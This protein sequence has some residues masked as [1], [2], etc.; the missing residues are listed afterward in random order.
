MVSQFGVG[1]RVSAA[2][3]LAMPCFR[4]RWSGGPAEPAVPC[5]CGVAEPCAFA[6]YWLFSLRRALWATS[7]KILSLGSPAWDVVVSPFTDVFA[8]FRLRVLAVGAGELGFLDW[9]V[10]ALAFLRGLRAITKVD[11]DVCSL[12][13]PV[14]AAVLAA[15][16]LA[17]AFLFC[18][19][20]FAAHD[21]HL[22]WPGIAG[23]KQSVHLPSSFALCR[24][25]LWESRADCLGSG[26]LLL[27]LSLLGCLTLF[28]LF[29]AVG[30][31][32]GLLGRGM[33]HWKLILLEYVSGPSEGASTRWCKVGPGPSCRKQTPT[34]KLQEESHDSAGGLCGQIRD[35]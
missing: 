15:C 28:L 22:I 7:L 4:R 12:E 21:G 9:G 23:W 13:P 11:S 8:G 33:V 24:R 10:P 20:F 1:D 6:A 26:R 17:V 35:G 16:R 32:T 34:Q 31:L 19:R 14:C 30:F 18:C 2:A 29:G 5:C 3:P 25:F 27:F